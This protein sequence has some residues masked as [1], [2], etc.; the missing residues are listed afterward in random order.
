MDIDDNN[1]YFNSEEMAKVRLPERLPLSRETVYE[2]NQD[3]N[4]T[5]RD[6][7]EL[8]SDRD[9][10]GPMDMPM[11]FEFQKRLAAGRPLAMLMEKVVDIKQDIAE[12]PTIP[13]PTDDNT[14]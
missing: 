8:Q 14:H 2:L 12:L 11:L 3:L 13:D 4:D 6:L 7:I 5:E 9:V 10:L 1:F